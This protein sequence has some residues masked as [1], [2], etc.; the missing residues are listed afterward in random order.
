MLLYHYSKLDVFRTPSNIYGVTLCENRQVQ[1]LLVPSD[2]C[3]GPKDVSFDNKYF[4]ASNTL[5]HFPI[6]SKCGKIRTRKASNKDTF[7]TVFTYYEEV[8]EEL[9]IDNHL[10]TKSF[11]IS[12]MLIIP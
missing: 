7:Y 3:Q 8:G 11:S 4:N 6:Q 9:Y 12:L 2:V 5:V 1:K 10:K